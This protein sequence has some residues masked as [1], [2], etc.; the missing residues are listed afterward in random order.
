MPTFNEDN[1]LDAELTT[2]I[3]NVTA[4]LLSNQKRGMLSGFVA[5]VEWTGLD[6]SSNWAILSPEEQLENV[7]VAQA[8]FMAAYYTEVQRILIHDELMRQRDGE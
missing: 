7:T 4:A 8:Q 2:A 5:M 1:E 6:G 3:Q